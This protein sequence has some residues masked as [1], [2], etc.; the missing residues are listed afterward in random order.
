[1]L[2]EEQ[3]GERPPLRR[4]LG[5]ADDDEFLPPRAFDLEPRLGPFAAIRRVGALRDDPLIALAAHRREKLLARSRDMLGELQVQIGAV[6][7]RAEALLALDVGQLG[8]VL[9][10]EREQIEREQRHLA[11]VRNRVLERRE[12]GAAVLK[13]DDFPIDQRRRNGQ[14]GRRLGDPGE[15]VGPVEPAPRKH[16]GLAATNRDQ[17]AIPVIFDLVDPAVPGRHVV[18]QRAELRVAEFG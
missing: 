17:R 3:R 7:Q 16:L 1:M 10:V 18:D 14:G 4:T 6:E 11:A 15:L 8:Q 12:I 5:P 2:A 13:G 9:A